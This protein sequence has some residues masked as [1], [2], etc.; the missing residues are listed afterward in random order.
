[1]KVAIY[2]HPLNHARPWLDALVAGFL[3]HGIK[4]EIKRGDW[5]RRMKPI[6]TDYCQ[7]LDCDVAVHW[8]IG[9]YYDVMG[10]Q[11]ERGGRSLV[12]ER[13]YVGDRFAYASLGFDGLNGRADFNL[14]RVPLTATRWRDLFAC[15]QP[16][17]DDDL[18]SVLVIGQMPGDQAVANVDLPGFYKA[19]TEAFP[20]DD[21]V[22]RE[23]PGL[24]P[25]VGPISEALA[26]ARLVV[27]MNSNSA[28][29]AVLAGVPAI[30]MDRGSMAWDVTTHSFEAEPIRPVREDWMRRLAYCQWSLEE[31]ASGEAW[32]HLSG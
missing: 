30:S 19:A 20:S 27:T 23:H 10:I 25:S 32:E 18:G 31:I 24:K 2:E 7:Y 3:R 11:K 26:G 12:V 22:L 14:D 28:V 4:P 6:D 1:M 15:E 29:D 9:R 13:G 16:W 17:R 5:P 21:V 8:G